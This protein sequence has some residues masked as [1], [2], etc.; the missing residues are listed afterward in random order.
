MENTIGATARQIIRQRGVTQKWVAERMNGINPAVS[1][2]RS[3]I[4]ATLAGERKMTGDELL[5]FCKALEINPDV[6]LSANADHPA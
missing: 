3:K 5:A 1:M 2:D 4:S 6:F